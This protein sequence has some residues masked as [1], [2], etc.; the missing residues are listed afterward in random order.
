MYQTMLYWETAYQV[1][2]QPPSVQDFA[3]QRQ[4]ALTS[5]ISSL[6]MLLCSDASSGMCTPTPISP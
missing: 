6:L 4:S 3:G 1:P 5:R 2:G